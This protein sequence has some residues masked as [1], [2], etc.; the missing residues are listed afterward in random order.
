MVLGRLRPK[1]GPDAR[2]PEQA[3]SLVTARALGPQAGSRVTPTSYTYNDENT[4]LRD[5]EIIDFW[6]SGR[7]QEPLQKAGREAPRRLEWVLGPL[8]Q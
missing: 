3:R 7:P 4:F 6:G 2:A 1:N 8:G 5:L